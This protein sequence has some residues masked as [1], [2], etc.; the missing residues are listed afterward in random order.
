M[1]HLKIAA[2]DGRV[3]IG[4][5]PEAPN[6]ALATG[7]PGGGPPRWVASQE[8]QSRPHLTPREAEVLRFV[9]E[10]LTNKQTAS[11][12]KVS[13][14]TV[15]KHRQAMM[16]KLHIHC[17]A[18]LVHYAVA[19]GLLF[20][21]GFRSVLAHRLHSRG[22]YCL[23]VEGEPAYSRAVTTREMQVLK[24]IAEGL[25][26]KQIA[27]ELNRSIKTIKNHRLE[28]MKRLN[29]H[30]V[31]GLTRY[32]IAQGLVSQSLD[33]RV[34]TNGW[35]AM[36]TCLAPASINQVRQTRNGHLLPTVT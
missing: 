2:V 3:K 9:A 21:K 18:G 28:L 7:R 4:Y 26:N 32:A 17:T 10:G 19:K 13:V 34:V 16:D 12:M 35:R 24:L 20:Q 30:H 27:G 15:E 22:G 31:A 5:P 33:L 36:V 14:K 1:P 11:E 8:V 25:E 6:S 29:I 23:S